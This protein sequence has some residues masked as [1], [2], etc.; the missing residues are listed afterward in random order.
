MQEFPYIIARNGTSDKVLEIGLVRF[1]KVYLYQLFTT[2]LQHLF[3]LHYVKVTFNSPLLNLITLGF[4][5][6]YFI[7]CIC[8]QWEMLTKR[9]DGAV[10]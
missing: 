5:R 8:S 1:S 7:Q 9:E 4:I 2:P 6:S 3:R 10:Y